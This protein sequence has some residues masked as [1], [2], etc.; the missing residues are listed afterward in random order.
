ML[1]CASIL[2]IELLFDYGLDVLDDDRVLEGDPLLGSRLE[3]I[4][5]YFGS[6]YLLFGL[7]GGTSGATYNGSFITGL[8]VLSR[9]DVFLFLLLLESSGWRVRDGRGGGRRCREGR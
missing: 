3:T 9:L 8:G 1:F 4:A 2:F 5:N 6:G 7:T